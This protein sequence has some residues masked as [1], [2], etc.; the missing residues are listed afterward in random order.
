MLLGALGSVVTGALADLAGWG[1]AYGTLAV[2]L[3][4]AVGGLAAV[5]LSDASL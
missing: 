1:V 3:A 4:L 5:R 2:L